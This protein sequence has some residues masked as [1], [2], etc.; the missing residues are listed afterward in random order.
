[1]TSPLIY[2]WDGEA[3][4]PLKGFVAHANSQFVVGERYR[5]E[6]EEYRSWISHNHQFAWLRSA[7]A[8]LPE[9][10]SGQFPNPEILR[11][12]ALIE[13]GFCTVQQFPCQT[14]AEA[15]R[16][17]A[18]ISAAKGPKDDYTINLVRGSVLSVYRAVSQSIKA[19]GGK[20][21]QQ[22]KQA[23]LEYVAGLLGVAPET[24]EKQR[25]AA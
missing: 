17:A 3:M 5:M 8:N 21:F 19:M 15:L 23:V 25:N 1:M 11:K 13:T 16:M 12:H 14:N 7:W 22:S 2:Q 24:L 4:V 20:Q 10:R 18:A 6:V 9:Y